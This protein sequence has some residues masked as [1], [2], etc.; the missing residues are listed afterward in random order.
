M[1]HILFVILF[2]IS[3][4]AAGDWNK[5]IHTYRPYLV[6]IEYFESIRSNSFIRKRTIT[7]NLTG[8][9]YGNEGMI[10]TT[11]AIFRTGTGFTPLR[12]TGPNE[13]P[14][15]ITVRFAD[16]EETSARFVGKDDDWGLG[17]LQLDSLHRRKGCTFYTQSEV[18]LGDQLLVLGV[19]SEAYQSLPFIEAI[20]LSARKD[21]LH[22]YYL[23][24]GS[25]LQ[26]PLG[27]VLDSR[28]R[29]IGVAAHDVRLFK[30]Q[31]ASKLKEL[32]DKPPVY[33]PQMSEN[34]KWL[35][36]T[37]QPFTRAMARYFH[38]DSLRGIL[39]NDVLE[40]SPARQAGLQT[41][42]VLLQLGDF[43]LQAERYSDLEHF[44]ERIRA[45]PEDSARVR[46]WREGRITDTH[47][48]LTAPPINRF[49][50]ESYEDTLYGFSAQPLT[51]D[52]LLSANLDFDTRGMWVSDVTSAGWADLAGLKIGDIILS[53]NNQPVH[54]LN[55]IKAR[56]QALHKQR[57]AYVQMFILRGPERLFV[58]IKTKY[59][60]RGD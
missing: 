59:D 12:V 10:V 53:I 14:G 48:H 19:L 44:R 27:L 60:T 37:M 3:L 21:G 24:D 34:K 54:N 42:D 18:H 13:P 51:R 55:D 5:A 33:T 26:Q 16:G 36:I 40:G 47:V 1:K 58:F 6:E 8:I 49:L 28:N 4:S 57:P 20:R 25:L 41:G 35:G 9:L 17:F 22:P 7:R 23:A 29:P 50:A 52:I 45:Y 32:L 56:L 11:S 46:Y 2:G 38:A 31:L 15:E 39:I 30:I 43:P